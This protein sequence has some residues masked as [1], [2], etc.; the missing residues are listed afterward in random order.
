MSFKNSPQYLIPQHILTRCMGVLADVKLPFIKNWAIRFFIWH[1]DVNMQEA[2][3]ENPNNY[4]TFNA[5]FTRF[6]KPNVRPICRKQNA[7]ISPADGKISQ[8]GL[9]NEGRLIQAKGHYFNLHDLLGADDSLTQLFLDGNFA[10]FYLSPKDYHRV[11]MPLT[12]T[13]KEMIYVPG[14]L[15][16]VNDNASQTIPQ[17]FSRNERV[18]CL[19]ETAAGSMAVILIGAM[20]VWKH[21]H[22]LGRCDHTSSQKTNSRLAL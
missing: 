8:F 15:F 1:Y 21:P 18:I 6:L 4:S 19:F 14:K 20:I 9:I 3:E 11:H 16:S 7:I 22:K 5:F 17:L 12:G 13:L 2:L 10:T